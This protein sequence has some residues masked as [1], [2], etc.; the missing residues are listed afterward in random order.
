M[1]GLNNAFY[2]D[3][4]PPLIK[5]S[6][7][8]TLTEQEVAKMRTFLSITDPRIQANEVFFYAPDSLN[9]NIEGDDNPTLRQ[10]S[11]AAGSFPGSNR[12]KY[13][14]QNPDG[15][16]TTVQE[17]LRVLWNNHTISPAVFQQVAI[18]LK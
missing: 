8:S 9:R 1:D 16:T 17:T 7:F 10:V 4:T 11:A 12:R 18:T 2:L 6:S 3:K 15:S 13:E 14:R 5:A